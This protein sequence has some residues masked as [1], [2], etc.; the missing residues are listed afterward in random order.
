[1]H[2]ALGADRIMRVPIEGEEGAAPYVV[3]VPD[4]LK[5]GD[6]I[7][8]DVPAASAA[9]R[10]ASKEQI[11]QIAKEL[12]SEVAIADVAARHGEA[13]SD[14]FRTHAILPVLLKPR[15]SC[16]STGLNTTEL[17]VNRALRKR[18]DAL[19]RRLLRIPRL[20]ATIVAVATTC[21]SDWDELSEGPPTCCG[22]ATSLHVRLP[23]LTQESR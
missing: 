15:C 6:R 14:P 7:D 5:P 21:C 10:V 18:A 2:E 16:D 11:V 8:V 3:Y 13:A 19:R 12:A 4:G 22:G 17:K 20:E 1:V 9:P 23:P